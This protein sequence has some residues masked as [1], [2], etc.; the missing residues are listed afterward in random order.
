MAK[1]LETQ[2]FAEILFAV[3]IGY[4]LAMFMQSNADEDITKYKI[5]ENL[6]RNQTEQRLSQIV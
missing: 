3:Q 1:A 2:K 5:Y 6:M 4:Q